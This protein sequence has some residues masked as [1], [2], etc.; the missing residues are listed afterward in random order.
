MTLPLHDC[1]VLLGEYSLYLCTC[2]IG[3]FHLA[4]LGL[5]QMMCGVHETVA[6]DAVNEGLC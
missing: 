4:A 6:I 5:R 3:R 1:F 2:L